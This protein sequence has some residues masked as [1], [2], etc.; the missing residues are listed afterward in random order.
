MGGSKRGNLGGGTL[1]TLSDPWKSERKNRKFYSEKTK[2]N[3]RNRPLDFV[4]DRVTKVQTPLF[5]AICVGAADALWV[6]D[7]SR[8]ISG[9]TSGILCSNRLSLGGEG[10]VLLSMAPIEEIYGDIFGVFF[11]NRFSS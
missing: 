8:G 2:K 3:G 1:G 9:G 6:S 5:R 7:S 11:R 10:I 4:L